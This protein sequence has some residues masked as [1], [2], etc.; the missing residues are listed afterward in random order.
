MD[1]DRTQA[2]DEALNGP[3][4]SRRGFGALSIGAGV[5]VTAGTPAKAAELPVTETDVTIKTADGTCDA[6]FIH[7]TTGTYPGV[8]IWPDALGL[9]PEFRKMGRRLAAAGYAV[10]VPNPFYRSAKA[11]V[12]DSAKFSF[13]NPED[14]GKLQK[15]MGSMNPKGAETDTVAFVAFLDAQPQMKK[16]SKIGTQGYCMGGPL[17]MRTAATMPDRIGAAASFHGGGL[18]TTNPDSPHLLVPKIKAKT[19][20]AVAENDDQKQPDAKDVL[21]KAFADAKNPAE[22]EVYPALH[23]W[24]VG[25]MPLQDGKPLYN[26][27][28]AERAWTRLLATYKAGLA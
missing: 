5:A 20:I 3:D 24:C 1:D 6:A 17:V 22:V 21:K 28:H 27:E 12:F 25:D 8:I 18:V 14:M 2:T 10:L 26:K 4:V 23:G 15:M 16:G 19:L 13:S 11:P 7:P 9:R